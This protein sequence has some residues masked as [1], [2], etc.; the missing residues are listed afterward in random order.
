MQ[1]QKSRVI[2]LARARRENISRRIHVDHFTSSEFICAYVQR[3]QH[4]RAA[5]ANCI[6]TPA[7]RASIFKISSSSFSRQ[8]T[9][10]YFFSLKK[11]SSVLRDT[12][13]IFSLLLSFIFIV[14]RPV[15]VRI[16]IK[17]DYSLFY[18]SLCRYPIVDIPLNY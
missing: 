9:S 17:I 7:R 3:T 15:R 1:L 11:V 8:G 18:M 12:N 4:K 6:N 14:S 2:F 13:L 10:P 16:R 5:P